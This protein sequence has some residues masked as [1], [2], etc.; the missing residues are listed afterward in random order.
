M[1]FI[2]IDLGTTFI[3]GAVLNTDTL[4]P[5]HVE[6]TPFPQRL[7]GLPAGFYEYDPLEILAAARAMVDRLAPLARD[8]QGVLWSTQMHGLVLTT[9]A[10]EPRSNLLTWLDERAGMPHPAGGGSYFDVLVGRITPRE[11]EQLGGTE[12]RPGLPVGAL[13]WLAE[14][15]QLPSGGL[16]PVGLADFVV[17]NLCGTC[18]VTDLSNAQAHGTLDI[19]AGDWHQSVSRKLGL[20][21]LIWPEI[22]RHGDIVGH[23]KVAGRNLPVFTPVGD[24]QCSLVGALVD[25]DELSLN[26]ST[27]SQVSRLCRKLQYGPYQTRPFFDG[28][29]VSTV[30]TIPAGRALNS[31]VTLLGE[32]ATAQGLNLADP[33]PYIAA[34]AGRANDPEMRANVS[35]FASAVGERGELTNL[36]ESELTVGHLFRAAFHNMADN[37][38]ACAERLAGEQPWR[39]LVF[40]GGLVQ[41]MELLRELICDRFGV[42]YRY[43]PVAEDAMLGLLVLGLAFSGRASSVRAAMQTVRESFLCLRATNPKR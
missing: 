35:F 37:F 23:I 39:R 1:S 29:Y 6:R 28:L 40:S 7:T 13:F 5:E 43:S 31:L 12:L 8:C 24:F 41:K 26:I 10:G 4:R 15:D 34:A 11:R 20:D 25:E 14:N 33:W 3:K 27:G 18:P 16:M 30:T 42:P 36:R 17:A 9:S 21:R 22:K 19:E 38:L 32:L 2:G